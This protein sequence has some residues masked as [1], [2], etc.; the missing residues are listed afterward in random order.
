MRYWGQNIEIDGNYYNTAMGKSFLPTSAEMAQLKATGN[1]Y[2]YEGNVDVY[3]TGVQNM[4]REI[5]KNEVGQV[6]LWKINQ[7]PKK[8]KII[9][10]L[11]KEESRGSNFCANS[12]GLYNRSGNDCVIWYEPWSRMPNLLSGSGNS[13]YQVLVH[14]L[15]HAVRQVWGK[16][17]PTGPL[18]TVTGA[19]A[20]PNAEELYSVTIE[21]MYLSAAR[22]PHRMLGAYVQNVPL[23]NRTDRDFYKQYGNE[24]ETWCRDMPDMTVQ[25]ER[26]YGYWNPIRVRRGVLDLVITL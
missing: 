8:V 14:E 3:E 5:E 20:F 18:A 16:W 13:P 1:Y 9:P 6:L 19:A 17:N 22:E 12:V 11:G 7:A 10:L 4:L 21:N 15:Q 2:Q 25:L 26:I 23:G 24:L